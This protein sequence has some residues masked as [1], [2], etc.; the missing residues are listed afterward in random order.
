[1]LLQRE[2]FDKGVI[3][4]WRGMIHVCRLSQHDTKDSESRVWVGA[5][6]REFR[7]AGDYGNPDAALEGLSQLRET[8]YIN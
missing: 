2:D 1:V 5:A 8:G 3:H 6:I 7:L 4:F